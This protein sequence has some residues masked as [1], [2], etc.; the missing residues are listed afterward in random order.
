[1]FEVSEGVVM[2]VSKVYWWKMR[3]EEVCE[4]EGECRSGMHMSNMFCN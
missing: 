1:M 4:E 3:M 2:R